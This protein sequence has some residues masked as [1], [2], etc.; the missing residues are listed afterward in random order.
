L[1]DLEGWIFNPALLLKKNGARISD[2]KALG[3]PVTAIEYPTSQKCYLNRG[4]THGYRN[5]DVNIVFVNVF[6][7]TFRFIKIAISVLRKPCDG[8]VFDSLS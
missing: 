5:K 7:A 8:F 2:A 6:P 4:R 1:R 3:K